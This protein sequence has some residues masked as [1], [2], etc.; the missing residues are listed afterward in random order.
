MNE[1]LIRCCALHLQPLPP[2]HLP[3]PATSFER[4]NLSKIAAGVPL[5]LSFPQS[6]A[7]TMRGS[8]LSTNL[9]HATPRLWQVE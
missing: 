2:P 1:I 8:S 9:L 7:S 3:R 6:Y 5:P 4:T